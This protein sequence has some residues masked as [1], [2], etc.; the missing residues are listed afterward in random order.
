MASTDGEVM[1][2]ELGKRL[3]HEEGL[4][5]IRE[6]IAEMPS[7]ESNQAAVPAASAVR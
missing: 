5:L 1:M 4:A 2:P 3:V 6:W 7:P